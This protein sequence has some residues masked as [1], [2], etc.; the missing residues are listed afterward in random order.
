MN[1]R[2]KKIVFRVLPFF[3][4]FG[5]ALYAES[6]FREIIQDIFKW[7]TSNK[8]KFIGK[9]IYFSVDLIY[10]CTWGLAAL[11]LTLD[12]VGQKFLVFLK[13]GIVCIL[14]FGSTLVGISAIDAHIKVTECTACDDGIR[15]LHWNEINYAL[16]ICLSTI[17]SVIPSVV[18]LMKKNR[19]PLISRHTKQ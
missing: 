6:F 19:R 9:N 16:I 3:L 17:I 18:R 11:I 15:K 1:Q 7:S 5:I 4:G 12:L 10:Y 13:N 8:I 2:V 14:I